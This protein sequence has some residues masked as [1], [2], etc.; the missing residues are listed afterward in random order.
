MSERLQ[1]AFPGLRTTSFQVTSPPDFNYNCIGWAAG[2][3]TD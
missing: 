2:V 1:V 3:V